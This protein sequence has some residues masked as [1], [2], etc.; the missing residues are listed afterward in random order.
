MPATSVVLLLASCSL[1]DA[2][3]GRPALRPRFAPVILS[4]VPTSALDTAEVPNKLLVKE[5]TPDKVANSVIIALDEEQTVWQRVRTSFGPDL[6][7][8]SAGMGT[9]ILH[10]QAGIGMTPISACCL[11]GTLCGSLLPTPIAL[12]AYC[13]GFTGM[14]TK[15]VLPSLPPAAL[16][17][18]ACSLLLRLFNRFGWLVGHGGRLGFVAQLA[19]TCT[20]LGVRLLGAGNTAGA[21]LFCAQHY[22]TTA[23][24]S[25]FPAMVA[26]SILGAVGTRTW[27]RAFRGNTRLDNIVTAT[28][29]AGGLACLL[30]PNSMR[31]PALAGT[32]VAMSSQQMLPGSARLLAA[33]SCCAVWQAL[34]SGLL[35]GGWGGKLGTA[36]LL[37]ACLLYRVDAKGFE[38]RPS[39][40][41]PVCSCLSR[42]QHPWGRSRVASTVYA[43]LRS[44]CS[45]A[46][47][48]TV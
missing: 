37:G 9:W 35:N 44:L 5:Q 18:V 7:V 30:L 31:G 25:A 41:Q 48:W 3:I 2:W 14:T 32:F 40:S 27:Q 45:L 33:A 36:A 21:S 29:A 12:A 28:S 47:S 11:V 38:R 24:L 15:A 8:V 42:Q 17:C 22:E 19:V 6:A 26:G 46:A 43:R 39:A 10:N 20:F 4:D 34:L 1:S 13:G 23:L 16:A